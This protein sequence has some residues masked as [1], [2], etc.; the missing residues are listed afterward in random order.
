MRQQTLI[1]I[2]VEV[3]VDEPY[4]HILSADK[5]FSNITSLL[6]TASLTPQITLQ[7]RRTA[8]TARAAGKRPRIY[9]EPERQPLLQRQ[10]S[11]GS[12][13]AQISPPDSPDTVQ[14]SPQVR[15]V[16]PAYPGCR[17]ILCVSGSWCG[18][19]GAT[20]EV[21]VFCVLLVALLATPLIYLV[22]S[23]PLKVG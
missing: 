10:S 6:S 3:Y 9:A 2:I 14:E 16:V 1:G 13:R 17:C 18:V 19:S 20:V 12:I 11:F 8:Y 21:L 5:V 4:A 22:T 23:T 15:P 7:P